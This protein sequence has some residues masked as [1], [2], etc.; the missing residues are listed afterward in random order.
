MFHK[1]YSERHGS[2]PSVS[3]ICRGDID[4]DECEPDDAGCVHRE[5]D[6][7]GLVEGLGDLPGEDSVDRADDDQEDGVRE[8][9]QVARVDR[10]LADKISQS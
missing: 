1:P 3:V 9:D 10:S 7:L 2:Y 6:E 8:G 5:P 4:G